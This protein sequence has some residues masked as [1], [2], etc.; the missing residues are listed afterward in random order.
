MRESVERHEGRQRNE[1]PKRRY[2]PP[3]SVGTYQDRVNEAED[4]IQ[5]FLDCRTSE[6][7]AQMEQDMADAV[8]DWITELYGSPEDPPFVDQE[9]VEGPTVD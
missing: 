9:Y 8:E 1:T 2:A 5:E 7:D 3:R 4:Q 6:E